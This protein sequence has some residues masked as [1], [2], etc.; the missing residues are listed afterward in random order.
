VCAVWL[1]KNP[2]SRRDCAVALENAQ[3]ALGNIT[4]LSSLKIGVNPQVYSIK[5]E[6]TPASTIRP[7]C[8]ALYKT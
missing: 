4:I 6:S 7:L 1:S 2:P 5:L 8:Q 3:S